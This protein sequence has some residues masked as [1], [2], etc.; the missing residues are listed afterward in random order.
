MDTTGLLLAVVIHAASI[1]D[2]DGAKTGTEPSWC[3][4]SCWA[5]SRGSKSSGLTPPDA[6]K[7]IAWAWATGGWLLQVVRRSPDSHPFEV[8]PRRWV[9]ER[10]LAWLSR[11]RRLSKDYEELPETGEAWVH[12]AM[13]H[14]MLKRLK[15]T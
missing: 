8:L 5:G 3:W 9:V 6:G 7:L 1:Q 13:V 10:T 14:L 12:I 2:R 11:C 15:P 4:P